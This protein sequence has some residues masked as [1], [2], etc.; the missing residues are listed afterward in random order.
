MYFD[1]NF[2]E[3]AFNPG[4]WASSLLLGALACNSDAIAMVLSFGS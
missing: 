3:D 2:L 4:I 1:A